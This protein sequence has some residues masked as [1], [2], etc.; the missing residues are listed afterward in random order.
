MRCSIATATKRDRT[1]I[2]TSPVASRWWCATPRRRQLRAAALRA[3]HPREQQRLL[4]LSGLQPALCEIAAAPSRSRA[5]PAVSRDDAADG[6]ADRVA[7]PRQ[8]CAQLAAA[9]L[10]RRLHQAPGAARR[11]AL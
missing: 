1:A 2:G 9:A 8:P 7:A 4:R 3:E 6:D 10:G 5:R 11:V